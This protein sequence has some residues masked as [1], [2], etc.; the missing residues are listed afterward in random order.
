MPACGA[1]SRACKTGHHSQQRF[2]RMWWRQIDREPAITKLLVPL[3]VLNGRRGELFNS[4]GL[5]PLPLTEPVEAMNQPSL[6]GHDVSVRD[7]VV[8][9]PPISEHAD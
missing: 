2:D 3:G 7:H 8:K 9:L 6:S 5:F 4:A 1:F